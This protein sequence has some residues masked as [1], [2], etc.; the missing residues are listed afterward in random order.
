MLGHVCTHMWGMFTC[1]C[2]CMCKGVH[3][4]GVCICVCT[5]MYAHVHVCRVTVTYRQ[6]KRELTARLGHG[7]QATAGV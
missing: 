6:L 7:F 2:L 4:V 3:Y 1:M 5:H